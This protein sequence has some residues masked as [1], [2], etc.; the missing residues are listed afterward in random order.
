MSKDKLVGSG[1]SMLRKLIFWGVYALV[2]IGLA[3]FGGYYFMQYR[4][5]KNMTA[6]Q[7]TQQQ[8]NQIIANVGKLYSLPKDEQPD[9]AT[10]K[11]KEALKKQYPFFDQAENADIVL[12]YKKAQIAILYRPSTKKIVKS[13]AVNVQ[14]QLSVKII[15]KQADREAA[16][17]Q[18]T[19]AKINFTDGGDAK[20]NYIGVSVVDLSGNN[21]TQAKA[22][23]DQ[24]KGQVIAALPAGEDKPANTDLLVIAGSA[25]SVNP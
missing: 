19:A 12:I 22:L 14:S 25:T 1:G 15:G 17:K 11:D 13:G 2:V 21:A 7:F 23:A 10:V 18:L 3:V 8:T 16:E 24:L 20:A 5:I 6:D 4:H 9:V